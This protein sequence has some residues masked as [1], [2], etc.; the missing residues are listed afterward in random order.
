MS[1]NIFQ[2][3]RG[4]PQ[5]SNARLSAVARAARESPPVALKGHRGLSVARPGLRRVY[6]AEE[7]TMASTSLASARAGTRA[8]E[9]LPGRAIGRV[10]E[11]ECEPVKVS[12][13]RGPPREL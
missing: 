2:A 12:E 8:R 4:G 5:P 13:A 6:E 10:Y 9:T 3:K 7:A 1:E 11:A